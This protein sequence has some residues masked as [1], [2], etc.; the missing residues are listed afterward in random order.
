MKLSINLV[1]AIFAGALIGSSPMWVHSAETTKKPADTKK[2]ATKT[3]RLDI[4]TAS[5]DE[6]KTLRGLNE[7]QAKKIVDGRPY[8]RRN[9]LLSKKILPQE[10]YDK[11]KDQISTRPPA[12]K[13]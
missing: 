1:A 4:N 9:E 8:K 12:T 10:T 2:P 13:G 6:L 3:D 7:A 11:V 5:V